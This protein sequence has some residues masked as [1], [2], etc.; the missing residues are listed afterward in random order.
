[1]ENEWF[2]NYMSFSNSSI[3][4]LPYKFGTLR[5]M[6]DVTFVRIPSLAPRNISA[7]SFAQQR[8]HS[9]DL[10]LKPEAG[11][12]T[13]HARYCV[14]RIN[15]THARVQF[16]FLLS[17]G[18]RLGTVYNNLVAGNLGGGFRPSTLNKG[19]EPKIEGF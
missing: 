7:I 2:S 8:L 6:P 1:M 16:L 9:H 5:I 12:S 14:G 11:T 4:G 13:Q 3:P 18:T 17:G 10:V 15:E 19:A